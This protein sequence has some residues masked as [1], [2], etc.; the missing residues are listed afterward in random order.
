MAASMISWVGLTWPSAR[1]AVWK[2]VQLGAGE[3][4]FDGVFCYFNPQGLPPLTHAGC[5]LGSGP[6]VYFELGAQTGGAP[7]E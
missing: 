7:V 4:G 2:A 3:A 5:R 6:P 1:A